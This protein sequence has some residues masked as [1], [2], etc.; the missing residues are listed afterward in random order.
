M[1]TTVKRQKRVLALVPAFI[2]DAIGLYE[3]M[4]GATWEK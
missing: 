1:T 2:D 4:I 3:I